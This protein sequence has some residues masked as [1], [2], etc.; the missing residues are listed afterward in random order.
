MLYILF[1]GLWQAFISDQCGE[2]AFT[3]AVVSI[4][5][6][7]LINMKR[8]F[9]ALVVLTLGGLAMGAQTTIDFGFSQSTDVIT[10]N[11]ISLNQDWKLTLNLTTTV[12]SGYNQWGTPIVSTENDPTAASQIIQV[13]AG[14][15][16]DSLVVK[17]NN[18]D[19]HY[20]V[21]LG[22][23]AKQAW[24]ATSAKVLVLDY[25]VDGKALTFNV[26]DADGTS[27][28]NTIWEDVS[29]ENKILTQ[30]KTGISA[31]MVANQNWTLPSGSFTYGKAVAVP[32]PATATLS[33]LALTGLA[34]RRR[35]K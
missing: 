29:F 15:A 27:I 20:K 35:R 6:Q 5:N 31:D 23:E 9:A 14:A 1:G 30:L 2:D 28:V 34:A 32:E 19:D 22:D 4:N 21:T 18:G 10:F 13:Y 25:E 3:Q 7:I 8:T 16:G 26:T 33:L 24:K 17:A 11:S 12:T